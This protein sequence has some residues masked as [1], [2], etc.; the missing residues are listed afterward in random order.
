MLPCLKN[1]TVLCN[2]CLSTTEAIHS[3]FGRRPVH[4]F[5]VGRDRERGVTPSVRPT[6]TRPPIKLLVY[7]N[8]SCAFRFLPG[9]GKDKYG[10]MDPNKWVIFAYDRVPTH[11]DSVIPPAPCF[12]TPPPPSLSTSCNKKRSRLKATNKV[13]ISRP[14]KIAA[15]RRKP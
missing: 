10:Y 4:V 9:T 11:R 14:E 15:M 12:P 8:E 2:L 6:R 5:V 1:H 7:S 13:D 3:P